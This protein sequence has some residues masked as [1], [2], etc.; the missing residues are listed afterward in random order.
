MRLWTIHPKYLDR[1]GLLAVWREG[2]LAQ[3]VLSGGTKG[4]KNHPQLLRFK[5]Q[6]DPIKAIGN[7]LDEIQI[8]ATKRNYN[9][10][11][12]KIIIINNTSQISTTTGQLDYEMKH[13]LNKLLKRSPEQYKKISLLENVLPHPIFQIFPGNVE[14][15]EKVKIIR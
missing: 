11:R 13:L 15:W 12:S 4:Y 9:F 8:E 10:N 2:L 1:Q 3:S 6:S 14:S 7:F 5:Q